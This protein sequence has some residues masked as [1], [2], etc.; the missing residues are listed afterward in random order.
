MKNSPLP[1]FDPFIFGDM[2]IQII[3][4]PWPGCNEDKPS[5]AVYQEMRVVYLY[6]SVHVR[7]S[8]P[9]EREDRELKN[10][11]SMAD[12]ELSEIRP[13]NSLLQ[14]AK[15]SVGNITSRFNSAVLMFAP[16]MLT[17]NCIPGLRNSIITDNNWTIYNAM[18]REIP[19]Y[20]FPQLL[21]RKL[22]GDVFPM[23]DFG[24][25]SLVHFIVFCALA[26]LAGDLLM[27]RLLGYDSYYGTVNDSKLHLFTFCIPFG[28]YTSG[29]NVISY[30]ISAHL[31]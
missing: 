9:N 22:H 28:I 10:K 20:T 18:N 11:M 2:C 30:G 13:D 15:V 7:E 31:E 29:K 23:R 26:V 6:A 19:I 21:F 14:H 4:I 24:D 5:S 27:N 25:F 12:F 16:T 8:S 17:G 3:D 1:E